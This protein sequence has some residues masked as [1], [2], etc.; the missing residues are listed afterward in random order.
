MNFARA[1]VL[2][3]ITVLNSLQ[4]LAMPER[5]VMALRDATP[6]QLRIWSAATPQRI[7]IGVHG[8]NDYSKAFDPLARSLVAELQATVYAYDQRG[9]GA[10]PNPGVWPGADRLIDDLREV[11]ERLRDRHPGLPI[12]VIGESMGGAVVLRA[13]T[14][15]PGL[16]VSQLILKA[17]ALWGAETM[18]WFQRAG[19]Q[20]MNAVAPNFTFSGRGLRALGIRPTDDPE[21]ARD[22]SRD[23]L[24]IK[25]TRVSS[26]V[27]VTDL[28]GQ[29]LHH[30]MSFPVPTLVLYGLNDRIIPQAPMCSWLTRLD[31]ESSSLPDHVQFL[32]YPQGWHLLTRQLRAAE[33]I[34]DI[35]Q[36]IRSSTLT[37]RVSTWSDGVTVIA[38]PTTVQTARQNVC[39]R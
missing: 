5:G 9:F 17:P 30:P 25:E 8:F 29:A 14:E 38:A 28:M 13:S 27:G 15:S 24:F 23:P 10:N 6:L 36:W 22:L 16:P 31:G 19:L 37:Q 7:V 1:A 39:Q 4:A 26:L 18:P 21:V 35:R 33:V 12:T 32:I 2:F 20:M 11:V 3:A 34:R